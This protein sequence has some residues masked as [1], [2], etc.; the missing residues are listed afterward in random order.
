VLYIVEGALQSVDRNPH[1]TWNQLPLHVLEAAL[2]STQIGNNFCVQRCATLRET[3]SFL[4]HLTHL[5][6]SRTGSIT[7]HNEGDEEEDD[8][9]DEDEEGQ[10]TFTTWQEK[11]KK[12]LWEI[13][14]W[15]ERV[16][17][18]GNLTITDVFAKQ[19]MQVGL[20]FLIVSYLSSKWVS[21]QISGVSPTKAKAITEPYPTPWRLA[22]AYRCCATEAER[23]FMLA[24]LMARGRRLGP[25]LSK[26]IYGT[27]WAK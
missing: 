14:R 22:E 23:E 11:K 17:K 21:F 5:I 16:S 6:A 12:A 27:M 9:D 26:R 18:S 8:S 15:E 2:I 20:W 3:V 13:T 24:G 7:L 1:K 25:A 4:K 19:L 10:Q